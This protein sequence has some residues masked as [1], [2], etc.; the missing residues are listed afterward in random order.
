MYTLR[1]VRGDGEAAFM[2]SL[3]LEGASLNLE[4]RFC[5]LGSV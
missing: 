2:M 1:S 5:F 4:L 3:G